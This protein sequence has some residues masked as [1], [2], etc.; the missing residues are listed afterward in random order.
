MNLYCNEELI[1]E[2]ID[3]IRFV[4][5]SEDSKI[6]EE[7]PQS[8]KIN[9]SNSRETGGSTNGKN[10]LKNKDNQ[11]SYY[12]FKYKIKDDENIDIGRFRGN[13]NWQRM[14]ILSKIIKVK[15]VTVAWIM[16]I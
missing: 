6:Y 4:N 14:G 7:K 15:S 9:E 1:Q 16:K 8:K 13:K 11:G 5:D 2:E 3:S 10:L 12:K